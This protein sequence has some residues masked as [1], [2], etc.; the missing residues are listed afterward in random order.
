MFKVILFHQ[1]FSQLRLYLR[2][3]IKLQSQ[4][5]H[6]EHKW[7]NIYWEML[8]IPDKSTGTFQDIKYCLLSGTHPFSLLL[9]PIQPTLSTSNASHLVF[10]V[11][12]YSTHKENNWRGFAM[13]VVGLHVNLLSTNTRNTVCVRGCLL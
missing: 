3:V 6:F 4:F 11:F 9:H 13:P 12:Y 5:D 2:D 7:V 8:L 1:I 10:S